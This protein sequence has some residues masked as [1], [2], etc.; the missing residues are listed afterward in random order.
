VT[1]HHPG[2]HIP[3]QPYKYRHGWIPVAPRPDFKHSKAKPVAFL[4]AGRKRWIAEHHLPGETVD[5]QKVTADPDLA[6]KV[7]AHYNALPSYDKKAEPAYRALADEIDKQYEFLTKKLGVKVTVTDKD[8]YHNVDELIADL[9]NHKMSVLSTKS[10]GGHPIFTN[11]QN[12][13][14]RAVHDA[15]AHAG[16]GRGFDRNGEEA[17]F[18]AH[19]GMMHTDL[20]RQALATETRGQNSVLITTG[21]FPEQKVAVLPHR[22]WRIEKAKQISM[23]HKVT[24][25]DPYIDLGKVGSK[26]K[27]GYIPE[28]PAAVALKHHKKPGHLSGRGRFADSDAKNKAKTLAKS[29]GFSINNRGRSPKSGFMVSLDANHGGVEQVFDGKVSA[30]DIYNHKK[31]LVDS[32]TKSHGG[33]VGSALDDPSH[34]HGA[35][36]DESTGKT[37]LDVSKRHNSIITAAQHARENNQLAIYDVKNG[38]TI[39]TKDALKMAAKELRKRKARAA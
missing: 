20:A 23:A 8:P 22:E 17:A 39:N 3:G 36:R 31:A 7:S 18:Q 10:T 12:D 30:S 27:H 19:Y 34:F 11:E 26:W 2:H 6:K 21:K 16:T 1:I 24:A 29:G 15:F 32:Y 33:R 37:Y 14:F 28:N 4:E 25:R 9:N 38:T 5:F 13:R 35:W